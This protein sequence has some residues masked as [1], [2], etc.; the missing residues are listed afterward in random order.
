M[1]RALEIVSAIDFFPRLLVI[2]QI[3]GLVV[4]LAPD[5]SGG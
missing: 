3:R 1:P 4:R 5:C 2:P